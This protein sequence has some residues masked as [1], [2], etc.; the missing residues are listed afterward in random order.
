MIDLESVTATQA[1]EAWEIVNWLRVQACQLEP[2]DH[3]VIH[4]KEGFHIGEVAQ[5]HP[6]FLADRILS[7]SVHITLTN[8]H[9]WT[10][11]YKSQTTLRVRNRGD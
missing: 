5:I 3:V 1:V 6:P 2:G 7:K 8:G 10:C 4:R 9:S 11:N